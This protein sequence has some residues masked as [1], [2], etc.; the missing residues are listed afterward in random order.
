VFNNG[1]LLANQALLHPE[2]GSFSWHYISRNLYNYLVRIPELSAK[3]PFLLLT[4]YGISLI[5]TTP[6]VLLLLPVPQLIRFLQPPSARLPWWSERA[7][8]AALLGRLAL[9]AS[10]LIFALYLC[11][12]WDGWRQFGCRYTLDFTP[13]LIVALALRND[14]VEGW[15]ARLLPVLTVASVAVNLW[16]VWWWRAHHW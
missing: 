4:D 14:F 11:Y 7:P 6:A 2:Y 5:A 12:F 3:P 9:L 13:F 16:G 1:Y 8:D 10:G 15:P